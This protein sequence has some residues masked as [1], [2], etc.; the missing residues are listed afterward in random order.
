ML[1]LFRSAQAYAGLPFLLYALLLQLP[2]FLWG[3][4]PVASG[5]HYGVA[6]N[7]VLRWSLEFPRLAA[8]LPAVFVALLGVQASSLSN[9]HLYTRSR[10][11]FAALGVMLVWALI[12]GTRYLHPSLPANCLLLFSLLSVSRVYKEEFPPVHLFNA[13]VWIGLAAL[14][15]PAYVLFLL[16]LFVAAS[17]LTRG[18]LVQLWRLA[19][20]VLTVYFLVGTYAY[21]FGRFGEFM[22]TQLPRWSTD[23]FSAGAPGKYA[24]LPLGLVLVADVLRLPTILRAVNIEGAKG[25]TVLYWLLLVSPFAVLFSGGV[26]TSDAAMLVVPAGVLFG[27]VLYHMPRRLAEVA[28]LLLFAAA[29][30]LGAG[31]I[32]AALLFQT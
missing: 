23:L 7:Y 17:V 31:T 19:V 32:L 29:W 21:F 8:L 4:G 16:L 22:S 26:S 24:L 9:R 1:T 11:Q 5:D 25:I 6:G 18:G 2:V 3:D 14:F 27:L 15:V 30:V 10:T 28:H 12:P 20:G 13:G